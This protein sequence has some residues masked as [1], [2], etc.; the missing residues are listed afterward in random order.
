MWM[1]AHVHTLTGPGLL[2]LVGPLVPEQLLQRREDGA[3]HGAVLL[4][5]HAQLLVPLTE[6]GGVKWW[7]GKVGVCVNELSV[8]LI[9]KNGKARE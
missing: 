4:R 1:H 8:W 6:P 3:L 7:W 2:V 9:G 5:G